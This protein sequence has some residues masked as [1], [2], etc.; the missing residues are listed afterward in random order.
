MVY[1]PPGPFIFG[2]EDQSNLTIANLDSGFWMDRFPVTN[3]QF[4]RF[5]NEK[6]NREEGGVAWMDLDGSRISGRRKAFSVEAGYEDHPVVCV[7]R[8]GAAAYA[9]S[10]GKQLPTEQKWEK[11][12][13]GMDG[14]RYPWG[15][16][17]S[18]ERCNT[19][20]GEKGGTT[21]VGLYGELGSSPY[22]GEDM[23]GNVWEWTDSKWAEGD[24]RTVLRGGAWYFNQ[25][26]AACAYRAGEL[27][28]YRDNGLGFRCARTSA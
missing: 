26:V 7:S 19:R 28:Q 12:A 8:Y 14:R 23:A 2:W 13:R 9:A 25:G 21:P 3:A 5:L 27:P 17:F 4:C 16:E 15:E 11:A 1:V 22:G 6:G 20:E 18:A 24:E 10:V